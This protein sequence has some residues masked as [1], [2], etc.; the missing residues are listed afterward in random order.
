MRNLALLVALLAALRKGGGAAWAYLR[1][2]VAPELVCISRSLAA[3]VYGYLA[4]T[5]AGLLIATG[6]LIGTWLGL[7]EGTEWSLWGNLIFAVQPGALGTGIRGGPGLIL[8]SL[9]VGL[10]A[11][12]Y[13]RL[14]CAIEIQRKAQARAKETQKK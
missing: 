10:A 14:R 3:L 11:A 6:Y 9:L 1:D 5:A 12:V 4:T 7:S 13:V 2:R 8:L